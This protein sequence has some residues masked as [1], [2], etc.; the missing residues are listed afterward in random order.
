MQDCKSVTT[1]MVTESKKITKKNDKEEK[2][3][4]ETT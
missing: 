4:I 2:E 1:P 3:G